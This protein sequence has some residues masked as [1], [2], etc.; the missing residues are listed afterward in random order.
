MPLQKDVWTVLFGL[1]SVSSA[2]TTSSCCS[3][4][5]SQSSRKEY[6][7]LPLGKKEVMFHTKPWATDPPTG[8][9]GASHTHWLVEQEALPI[10][11][12]PATQGSDHS[13]VLAF[14]SDLRIWVA[15]N[16]PVHR[17]ISQGNVL[18]NEWLWGFEAERYSKQSN[19]K[20][21]FDYMLKLILCYKSNIA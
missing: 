10:Y 18:T 4:G 6:D 13:W 7:C 21:C 12:L 5:V 17:R 16:S 3:P 20:M 1:L 11:S 19:V 2:C 15:S 14:T 8:P 9:W